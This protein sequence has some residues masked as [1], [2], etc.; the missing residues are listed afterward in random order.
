MST[1]SPNEQAGSG[2]IPTAVPGA[3]SAL[4]LLLVIN[5]LNYIDRYLLAAVLPKI[6]N[7]P[8]FESVSKSELGMLAPAFVVVYMLAAPVFGWLGDRMSRWLI[9]GFGVICW[10]VASGATGLAGS[11]LVLLVTRCAVG[12]GEAAY[13][14]V[15]PTLLSDMF[16]VRIRG[17]VMAW[18]YMA[19]PVGSALGY[20][21]GGQIAE[22]EHLGWRWAFY[23]VV[24]PGILLGLICFIMREPPVGQSDLGDEGARKPQPGDYKVLLRIPSFLLN[25]VA[26]TGMCF[27][28]GGL[29]YWMPYYIYD[30]ET[31]FVWSPRVEDDLAK[32]KDAVPAETI[33]KL[34]TLGSTESFENATA[35]RAAIQPLLTRDEY[36]LHRQA[37]LEKSRSE[38]SISLGKVNFLFGAIVAVS[39]LIA[40]LA[41]GILG[42]KLRKKHPGSYFFVSGWSAIIGLPIFLGVLL[43]PFPLAW[44]LLF[45]A[46]FCLFINTGPSNTIL[47]N[48]VPPSIR[49]TAFALNILVIHMLGDAISPFLIGLIADFTNLTLGMLLVSMMIG[50]SGIVW[51]LGSRHLQR[52]TQAAPRLLE[53][54]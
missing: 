32:G 54:R 18:F 6:E 13:G 42:D 41:G 45:I 15:A 28:L 8:A 51:V 24:P 4:A 10:S 2:R 30:R 40:T 5:L 1:Q 11:F 38:D 26:A 31:R 46:V 47:A 12:I 19:I 29:S 22:I 34:K 39:G 50:F 23:L 43:V 37:I 44:F 33:A 3:Y 52:D 21:F 48:V 7:D 36:R 16:P 27:A 53:N 49:S 25:T 20:V 9:V 17:Q 35:F 14:P